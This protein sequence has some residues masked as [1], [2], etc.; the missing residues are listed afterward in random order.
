MLRR[1]QRV[2]LELPELQVLLLRELQVLLLR[3]LERELLEPELREQLEPQRVLLGQELRERPE[4][5]EPCQ[6]LAHRQ[7]LATA[8][9][10]L[11]LSA[12]PKLFFEN[13]KSI[14]FC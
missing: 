13:S 10:T 3:G 8:F 14:L 6:L 9:Q 1:R 11:A 4:R 5:P 7:S 2:L 12:Q